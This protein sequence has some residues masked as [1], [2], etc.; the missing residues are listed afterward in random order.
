MY[1]WAEYGFIISSFP[2]REC[3]AA[4]D[5]PLEARRIGLRSSS[6]SSASVDA[7]LRGQGH[8]QAADRH[9]RRGAR[10][11]L[12][13]ELYA[14]FAPRANM[15][16]GSRMLRRSRGAPLKFSARPG[17]S[18]LGR[19]NP[20]CQSHLSSYTANALASTACAT[21]AHAAADQTVFCACS[22]LNSGCHVL[23]LVITCH[24]PLR[25]GSQRPSTNVARA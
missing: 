18:P 2:W 13:A 5:R 24:W 22:A 16:C 8:R 7:R 4:G 25:I 20:K 10:S 1:K 6:S 9:G 15:E 21:A 23:L 19:K 12:A 11:P 17:R 14:V 3:N